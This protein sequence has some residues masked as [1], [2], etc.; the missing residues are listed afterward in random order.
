MGRR[1]PELGKEQPHQRSPRGSKGLSSRAALVR[2]FPAEGFLEHI[3]ISRGS[4]HRCAKL[5]LFPLS[6]LSLVCL[7]PHQRAE[8][9]GSAKVDPKQLLTIAALP[10]TTLGLI[11]VNGIMRKGCQ[12]FDTPGVP[13][14]YQLT[15]ILTGPEVSRVDQ[16]P[17][18]PPPPPSLTLLL[19]NGNAL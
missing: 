6:S 18:P 8:A 7:S 5:R 13:H 9:G 19:R 15:S 11:P 10:G 14:P 16:N 17:P 1:S 3:P 2:R 12:M 4:F